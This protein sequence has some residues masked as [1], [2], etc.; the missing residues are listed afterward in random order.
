M[1]ELMGYTCLSPFGKYL[2]L[3][4]FFANVVYLPGLLWRYFAM[5]RE[6]AALKASARAVD[7]TRQRDRDAAQV[8]NI[9]S[10][11]STSQRPPRRS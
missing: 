2:V 4:L 8:W 3:A 5:K 10:D 1:M 11:R 6:L 9:D 7:A